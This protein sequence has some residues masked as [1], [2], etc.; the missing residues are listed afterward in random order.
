MTRKSEII[1]GSFIINLCHNWIFSFGKYKES[2]RFDNALETWCFAGHAGHIWWSHFHHICWQ[3]YRTWKKCFQCWNATRF[4]SITT[5]PV[6][7]LLVLWQGAAVSRLTNS[8]DSSRCCCFGFHDGPSY[9]HLHHLPALLVLVPLSLPS[10]RHRHPDAGVCAGLPW[11]P[12]CGLVGAVPG[13]EALSDLFV[14]AE[15]G[16]GGCF[17]AAQCP[18]F[19]PLPDCTTGLGVWLGCVQASA[20]PVQCEHVCVHLPHLPDEL[21]P[22]AGRNEAFPVPEIENQA[23]P[24]GYPAGGLDVSVHPVPADAFLPQVW[25]KSLYSCTV[26]NS[27]ICKIELLMSATW[28]VCPWWQRQEGSL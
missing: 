16:S 28:C 23:L 13:E 19:P 1:L 11:E 21:G 3:T 14:G 7:C 5:Y 22:L 10:D 18:L 26:H 24:A 17:C 20:L 27:V 8:S 6:S 25:L 4:H 2:G 12:V 9:Q 15:S